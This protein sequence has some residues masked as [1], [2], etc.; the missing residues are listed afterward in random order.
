[1]LLLVKLQPKARNF[2]KSNTLPWVFFTFFKLYKWCQIV[3]NIKWNADVKLVRDPIQ[4]VFL[5]LNEFK[6]SN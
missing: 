5:I 1:M 3:Q 4:I 2:T 6:R